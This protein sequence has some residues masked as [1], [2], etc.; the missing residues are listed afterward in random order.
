MSREL[1]LKVNRKPLPGWVMVCNGCWKTKSDV[2]P[3]QEDLPL[4]EFAA[5]G[6]FIGEVADRCPACV[7]SLPGGIGEMAT[8]V[9]PHPMMAPVGGIGLLHSPELWAAS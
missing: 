9:R 1:G 6:W 7:A 8:I 5:A 2:R 4:E 3:R